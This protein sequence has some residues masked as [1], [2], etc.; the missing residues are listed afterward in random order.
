MSF[1]NELKSIGDELVGYGVARETVKVLMTGVA[2]RI[3]TDWNSTLRDLPGHLYEITK[4]RKLYRTGRDA[5][6]NDSYGDQYY[7]S[8][9]GV[10][11]TQ[12]K[13]S[14]ATSQRG[15]LK[16]V[17][18]ALT[19]LSGANGE[20][21][22]PASNRLIA[23][24]VIGNISEENFEGKLNS[25]LDTGIKSFVKNDMPEQYKNKNWGI[26]VTHITDSE[27]GLSRKKFYSFDADGNVTLTKSQEKQREDINDVIGIM[28][29]ATD[30]YNEKGKDILKREVQELAQ[31][32]L[33]V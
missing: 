8:G 24:I 16:N 6:E 15:A 9:Q 4:L 25:Y 10:T 27:Q 28:I 20:L 32:F 18:L 19:Q 17:G 1:I 29:L 26:R 33:V 30:E 11:V 13:W 7:G 5:L 21:P 22:P 14:T 12:Q 31:S 2:A 3:S 23:D